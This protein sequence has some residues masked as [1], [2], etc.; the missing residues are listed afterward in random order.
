MAGRGVT[1]MS[2]RVRSS[3]CTPPLQILARSMHLRNRYD[4]PLALLM[5]AR[6]VLLHVLAGAN[7]DRL[8]QQRDAAGLCRRA[9]PPLPSSPRQ[10][11]LE[12]ASVAR[13]HGGRER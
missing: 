6:G 4:K 2:G 3:S 9:T 8:Q 1:R 11:K 10:A 12:R 7:L 5:T 13:A